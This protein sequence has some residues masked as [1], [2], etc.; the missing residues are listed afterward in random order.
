MGATA[1]KELHTTLQFCVQDQ[2]YE[3]ELNKIN[4]IE[5]PYLGTLTQTGTC[6]GK[7]GFGYSSA[8]VRDTYKVL[9]FDPCS[10]VCAIDDEQCANGWLVILHVALS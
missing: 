2:F 5:H 3:V 6:Y 7:A 9:E 8:V 10:F 1:C 4:E